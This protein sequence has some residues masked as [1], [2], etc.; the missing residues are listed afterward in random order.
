MEEEDGGEAAARENRR[1]VETEANGIFNPPPLTRRL[2][3]GPGTVPGTVPGS[4]Y[5][6]VAGTVPD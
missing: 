6:T 3:Y 1:S 2:Q 5:R 4:T